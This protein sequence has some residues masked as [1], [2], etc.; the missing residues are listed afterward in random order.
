M[1]GTAPVIFSYLTPQE[2][3]LHAQTYLEQAEEIA[4][5][6]MLADGTPDAPF[7]SV[8]ESD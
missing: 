7:T 5:P 8:D 3:R 1:A 2:I 4:R 6:Y